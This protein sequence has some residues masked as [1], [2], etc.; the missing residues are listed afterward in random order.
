MAFCRKCGSRLKEGVVFCGKCGASVKL[1]ELAKKVPEKEG[2]GSWRAREATEEEQQV[3]EKPK[4]AEESF[5]V[6]T[7]RGLSRIAA[8]LLDVSGK[9]LARK[10]FLQ[11]LGVLIL[12][13]VLYLGVSRIKL[14]K[15]AIKLEYKPEDVAKGL[16]DALAQDLTQNLTQ[17]K[18]LEAAESLANRTFNEV[19]KES[20][21]KESE[22]L[23]SE[24]KVSR[25]IVPSDKR[26][27]VSIIVENPKKEAVKNFAVFEN[28]PKSVAKSADEITR[29][30]VNGK[31]T[32][33]K[34][35][36]IV[37]KDPLIVWDFDQVGAGET[38]NVTYDVAKE[39]K[40]E[41]T[42]NYTSPVVVVYL[43]SAQPLKLGFFSA[44]GNL[45]LIAGV[46]IVLVAAFLYAGMRSGTGPKAERKPEGKPG[47]KP[48][49]EEKKPEE[50]KAEEQ[51]AEKEKMLSFVS[52]MRKQ[53]FTDE[54][55]RTIL[56][57]EHGYEDKTI[58]E[59]LKG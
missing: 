28:I 13:L 30:K 12:L 32:P 36:Q 29:W 1:P 7:T 55:L 34:E 19:E 18:Y 35:K 33:I 14:P 27:E 9:L 20:V 41:D 42:V 37:E 11:A 54:Q 38:V 57:E 8:V 40:K 39:L 23:A 44:V 52:K 45:I 10:E 4:A 17:N 43:P 15:A 22:K 56:K 6:T 2:T 51:K 31:E 21:K 47:E 16:R 50:K 26:S 24:L 46:L 53:G 58:E 48:E 25:V 59:M 49:A 3:E 5:I